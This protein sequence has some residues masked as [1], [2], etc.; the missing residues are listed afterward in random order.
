V[1]KALGQAGLRLLDLYAPQECIF[2]DQLSGRNEA[3]CDTCLAEFQR[4]DGACPRCGLPDCRGAPCPRCL[5]R[6]SPVTRTAAPL[7]Y[8]AAVAFLVKRW[9]YDRERNVAEIAAMIMLESAYI[10]D[11]ADLVV[12]VPLHWRRRL[13]RGFNQSEDLLGALRARVPELAAA[14]PVALRRTRDTPKQTLAGRRARLG[15]LEKAFCVRGD[16]SGMSVTLLDDVCTT[17]ATAT[18]AASALLHAGAREVNLWCLARTPAAL[19]QGVETA[20][21]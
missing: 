4:N 8:D 1:L 10:A 15:N 11:H 6:P 21:R 2:C 9:K 16:V 17:G 19:P 3:L 7:V 12:P 20:S 5:A 13:R 18:A 14:S